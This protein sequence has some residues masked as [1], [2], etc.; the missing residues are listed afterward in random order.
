MEEAP[1]VLYTGHHPPGMTLTRFGDGV[2]YMVADDGLVLDEKAARELRVQLAT[3]TRRPYVVVS[4]LRGVPYIDREA[5]ALFA[6]DD[7]GTVLATAVI[8]GSEG[9]IRIL[10][11]RWQ[12]DNVVERPVA[13]FE[14]PDAA[15]AWGH[16]TAADL[17]AAGKLPGEAG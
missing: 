15:L 8:A 6:D 2:I 10:A 13:V 3:V 14:G 9:P 5:R 1:P 17:R 16:A 11:D 4:D 12:A 7:N